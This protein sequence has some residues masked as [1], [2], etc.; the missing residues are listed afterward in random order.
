MAKERQ[1]FLDRALVVDWLDPDEDLKEV[2]VDPDTFYDYFLSIPTVKC[3]RLFKQ[4]KSQFL[5]KI[6]DGD[7]EE[8]A[9]DLGRPDKTQAFQALKNKYGE[10]KE[11]NWEWKKAKEQKN[12]NQ[13]KILRHKKRLIENTITHE[14]REFFKGQV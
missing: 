12:D 9:K 7:A 1:D 6:K 2:D 11:V 10:L 4:Y 13:I 5:S 8:I 14:I 3:Q